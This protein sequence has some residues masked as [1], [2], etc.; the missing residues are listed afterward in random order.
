MQ[1]VL[2]KYTLISSTFLKRYCTILC[3]NVVKAFC[4]AVALIDVL[5]V[6]EE[7]DEEVAQQHK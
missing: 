5:T 6:F 2:L 1:R 7:L 3:R 4:T